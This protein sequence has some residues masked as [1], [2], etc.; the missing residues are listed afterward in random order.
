[1]FRSRR[2]PLNPVAFPVLSTDAF[3]AETPHDVRVAGSGILVGMLDPMD[4]AEDAGGIAR[5]DGTW[6]SRIAYYE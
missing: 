3:L 6:R 5:D 2:Q 4:T 1:V